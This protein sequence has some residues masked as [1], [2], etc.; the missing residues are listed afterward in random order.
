[1]DFLHDNTKIKL[2]KH[3][4]VMICLQDEHVYAQLLFES[5]DTRLDN[6]IYKLYSG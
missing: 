3:K 4:L 6:H 1:M 2:Q 5:T